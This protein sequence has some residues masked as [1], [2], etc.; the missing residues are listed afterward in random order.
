MLK[1]WTL[2]KSGTVVV[3][4]SVA[5]PDSAVKMVIQYYWKTSMNSILKISDL[6]PF[7]FGHFKFLSL[8]DPFHV[9]DPGSE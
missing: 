2:L 9:T 8:P 3:V 5:D 4:V 6:T 1:P 7:N